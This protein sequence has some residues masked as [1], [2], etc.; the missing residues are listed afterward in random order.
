MADW[1]RGHMKKRVYDEE[2][3]KATTL[4]VYRD[5]PLPIGELRGMFLIP[6][7]LISATRE[8]FVRIAIAGMHDCG[9]EGMAFWAG[10]DAGDACTILLQAIV[11][12]AETSYGRVL[13]DRQAVGQSARAARAQRLGILCQ[14]HS[15]PGTDA[16]H[17][18]G[19]DHMVLMPFEGMLSIVVPNYGAYFTGIMRSCVHQYQDGK[20]VLCTADSVRRNFREIPIELDLTSVGT[21]N[22]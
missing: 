17:S 14:V 22:E 21:D 9:H 20:W 5:H 1:V 3:H 11:P 12:A 8:A 15:H 16:R 13:A 4:S 18:E 10:R 7:P 2:S 6:S 19:D